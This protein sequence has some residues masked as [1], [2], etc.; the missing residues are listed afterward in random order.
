MVSWKTMVLTC[1]VLHAVI[2]GLILAI[3]VNLIASNYSREVQVSMWTIT[4]FCMFFVIPGLGFLA[5]ILIRRKY[6]AYIP[7]SSDWM[8]HFKQEIQD[9]GFTPQLK[10]VTWSELN[11]AIPSKYSGSK[12]I[13]AMLLLIDGLRGKIPEKG[14][15]REARDF[16]DEHYPI[17]IGLLLH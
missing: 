6:M 7:E 5:K 15:P 14:V 10:N 9:L 11:Q 12:R 16:I 2:V 1:P 13:Y 8:Y 17:Y 3:P 4:M